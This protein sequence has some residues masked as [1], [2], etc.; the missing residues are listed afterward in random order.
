MA[1]AVP[2]I[3]I[4]QVDPELITKDTKGTKTTKNESIQYLEAQVIGE[5]ARPPNERTESLCVLRVLRVELLGAV[6][7]VASVAPLLE[8]L[9]QEGRNRGAEIGVGAWRWRRVRASSRR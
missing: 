5:A 2:V 4:T 6:P 3:P 1:A 7:N 9:L 8:A